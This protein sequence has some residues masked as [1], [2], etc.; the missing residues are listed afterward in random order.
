M[1]VKLWLVLI[2]AGFV[3]VVLLYKYINVVPQA[4]WHFLSFILVMLICFTGLRY[5]AFRLREK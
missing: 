3:I 2:I 5:V 4:V 1:S